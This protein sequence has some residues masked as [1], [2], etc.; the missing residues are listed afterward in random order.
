MLSSKKGMKKQ[1]LAFRAGS[2]LLVL[3]IYSKYELNSGKLK[4]LQIKINII[5][6]FYFST[7]QK[8]QLNKQNF[9]HFSS[10][11]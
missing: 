10:E 5:Q 3:H 4:V 1:K 2:T 6:I 11:I 8:L 7:K 9:A